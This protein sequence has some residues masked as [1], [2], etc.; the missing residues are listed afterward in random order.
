DMLVMLDEVIDRGVL[1]VAPSADTR[2]WDMEWLRRWLK[3]PDRPAAKAVWQ[4]IPDFQ[5]ALKAVQQGGETI[6]VTGSFHTVG[7]VMAE[8]GLGDV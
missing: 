5:E 4:L 7:D 1:T 3:E 8:L 2:R 6:L